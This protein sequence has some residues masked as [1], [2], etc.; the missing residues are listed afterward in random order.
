[1]LQKTIAAKHQTLRNINSRVY[2]LMQASYLIQV[3]QIPQW[4]AHHVL[5]L[6]LIRFH[7]CF[8]LSCFILLLKISKE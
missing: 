1:M 3:V 2:D 8:L 4:G 7:V 6:D 5:P